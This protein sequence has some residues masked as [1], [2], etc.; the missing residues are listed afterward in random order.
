[1]SRSVADLGEWGLIELITQRV[2]AAPEGEIWSGDDAA[3]VATGSERLVLTTD[4]LVQGVDFDFAYCPPQDAGWKAM[5][6]N[7]SDIAAMGAVPRHAVAT[8][9]LQP[10]TPV[11]DVESILDGLQGAADMYGTA[12]VGGDVSTASELSIGVTVAGFMPG[13]R[14]PATR[15]GAIGG[16]AICVTGELGGA[17]GGLIALKNK[18]SGGLRSGWDLGENLESP[19]NKLAAR[20][21][22]PTARL[23]ESRALGAVEVTAMIDVSDGLIADLEHVLDASGAG[24]QLEPDM[25]P[26]DDNL[27]TLEKLV[28]D[29]DPLELALTGGEDYELI[30]TLDPANVAEARMAVEHMGTHLTRIGTVMT[31]SERKLGERSFADIKE[32][33]WEHF[34]T[35]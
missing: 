31:G 29:L 17:A 11:V 12:L 26:V 3:V 6:V 4:I 18:P 32:K 2:G 20:Q 16:D 10:E 19:L 27:G 13:A 5:A 24:C 9:G 34:R 25:I 33:G 14:R 30:V 8:L 28:D 22:R 21:L 15:S 1:M 35:P 23:P 7:V